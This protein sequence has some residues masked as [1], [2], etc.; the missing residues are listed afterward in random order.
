M[1]PWHVTRA[2]E[3]GETLIELVVSVTIMGS[4][5]AVVVGALTSVVAGATGQRTDARAQAELVSF[6]QKVKATPLI[7]CATPAEY[8]ARL[9]VAPSSGPYLAQVTRVAWWDTSASAFAAV[10]STLTEAVDATATTIRVALPFAVADGDTIKV[11][12]GVAPEAMKVT[13]VAGD[14]LTVTRA[15]HP[16][17]HVV[18]DAV[19]LCP[20]GGPNRSDLQLVDATVTGPSTGVAGKLGPYRSTISLAKRGPLLIPT[21]TTDDVTPATQSAGGFVSD[22][23]LL[24]HDGP[25]PAGVEPTGTMTFKLFAPADA[26][27]AGPPVFTSDVPVDGFAPPGGGPYV[28]PP[29]Q[30]FLDTPGDGPG[31]HRWTVTYSGDAA[32]QG[33]SS[34]CGAP[35]QSVDLEKATPTLVGEPSEHEAKTG[36]LGSDSATLIGG[37]G[38]DPDG[39]GP[40]VGGP[41]GR[42]SF[43]LLAGDT[44]P[45]TGTIVYPPDPPSDPPVGADVDRGNATYALPDAPPDHPTFPFAG[46]FYWKAMYLGDANNLAAET[47]CEDDSQKVVVTD[48]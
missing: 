28:A 39:P 42:V 29:H 9:G 6:A 20:P 22:D 17:A 43:V 27:C 10:T 19:T 12:S 30:V 24:S 25:A 14:A 37:V 4:V 45:C 40:L 26:D 33:A 13:A 44:P 1:K 23:A 32:F 5:V 16:D 15:S 47:S 38:P 3:A 34:A 35:G 2:R 21:L 48:P 46:V 36:E 11:G 41:T 8:D 7:P 18:G 31:A